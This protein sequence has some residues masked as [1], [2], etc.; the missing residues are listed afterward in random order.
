MISSFGRDTIPLCQDKKVPGDSVILLPHACS[1]QFYPPSQRQLDQDTA[2]KTQA[3][4]VVPERSVPL[5]QNNG[6][7][8]HHLSLTKWPY[9]A[10]VKVLWTA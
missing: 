2:S 8:D 10:T 4:A 5:L 1:L 7:V 9:L 3:Y 6:L